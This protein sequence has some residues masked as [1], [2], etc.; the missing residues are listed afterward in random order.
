MIRNVCD[1][2]TYILY[3]YSDEVTK[4]R[5]INDGCTRGDNNYGNNR[6]I[7]PGEDELHGKKCIYTQPV[8]I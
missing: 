2:H 6:L 7:Y 8:V 1:T 4:I 3:D 5:V